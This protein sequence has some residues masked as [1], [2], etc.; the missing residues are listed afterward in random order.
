MSRRFGRVDKIL[1][2]L[3]GRPV[4]VHVLEP[5]LKMPGIARIVLALNRRNQPGAKK[6]LAAQGWTDRVITCL[7]GERRQDSVNAAFKKL[8]KCDWVIIHDGA[9]PLV[10]T[11]LIERG[12]KAVRQTGAAIA[13][14]P[15]TDTI[16]L[17]DKDMVVNRTMPREKLYNCQTP[18]V[19]SYGLLEKAFEH[20]EQDVTDE[21][22]L[23][24]LT[25]GRVKL[26]PGAYDNI[27]ITTPMDLAIAESLLR[28]RED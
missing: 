24:E 12:L 21:A 6:L 4:L 17:A 25:G 18:Q 20:I 15:T 26:Y 1:A 19:F 10:T 3:A 22:Q 27:K 16:K 2:P 23:I 9:R 28:L 14:V 8:G 7:G 13:A 5:F 11:S